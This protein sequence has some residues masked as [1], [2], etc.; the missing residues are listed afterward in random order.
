MKYSLIENSPEGTV[1]AKIPASDPDEN[2]TLSFNLKGTDENVF[3]LDEDGVLTVSD[4]SRL[5]Y[6][7]KVLILL[8]K[9]R[10]ENY[11]PLGMLS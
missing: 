5:D 3:S 10:M 7:N 6:E 2:D 9:L 11:I 1:V 8:L 4:A